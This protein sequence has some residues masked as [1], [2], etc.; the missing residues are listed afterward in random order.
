MR[1]GRSQALYVFARLVT[2]RKT[3]KVSAMSNCTRQEPEQGYNPAP[4]TM[5]RDNSLIGAFT[6]VGGLIQIFC[7]PLLVKN[8]FRHPR[9]TLGLLI[10]L[11]QGLCLIA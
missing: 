3:E 5:C 8:R 9:Q 10:G 6:Q 1:V 11:G 7:V 4:A 2:Q